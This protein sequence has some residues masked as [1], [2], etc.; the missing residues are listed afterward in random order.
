MERYTPDDHNLIPMR[1]RAPMQ[2]IRALERTARQAIFL[3]RLEGAV[4]ALRLEIALGLREVQMEKHVELMER[5]MGVLVK[6]E[7]PRVQQ[8]LENVF[9][10]WER[11]SNRIIGGGF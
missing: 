8:A 6:N 5:I 9:D 1:D 2:E 11:D 7:N 10:E 3:T 4:K